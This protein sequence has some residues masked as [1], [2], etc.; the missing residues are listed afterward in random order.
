MVCFVES[1]LVVARCPA[2]LTVLL[3]FSYIPIS[4]ILA[5]QDM[6]FSLFMGLFSW[7]NG[8]LWMYWM[9]DVMELGADK[10][11][12]AL[13][14][15]HILNG[16]GYLWRAKALRNKERNPLAVRGY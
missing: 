8:Y 2:G 7:V 1:V 9:I 3:I 16:S 11:W 13:C 10:F 14:L 5:F 12:L 4:C 15:M 6:K